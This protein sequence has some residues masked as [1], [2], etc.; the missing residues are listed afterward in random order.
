LEI[1]CPATNAD[2]VPRTTR[3]T[4]TSTCARGGATRG[5]RRSR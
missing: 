2:T 1:A 4:P 3:V 5:P